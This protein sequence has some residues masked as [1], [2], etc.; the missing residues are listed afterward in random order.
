MGPRTEPPPNPDPSGSDGLV[1]LWTI[2]SNECVKTLDAHEDKVWG[3]HCSRLDDRALTG[4]SDS[5]VILW[6]V[7]R[8]G[9]G[10][11]WGGGGRCRAAC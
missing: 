11:G 5:C 1:K 10:V 2:K 8:L 6:K 3:L 4:A 7:C 9:A